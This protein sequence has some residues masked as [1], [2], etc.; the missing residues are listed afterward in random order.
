[1]TL[2]MNRHVSLPNSLA[3][4]FKYFLERHVLSISLQEHE[5]CLYSQ[6]TL[7]T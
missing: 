3:K 4:R 2:F 7:H 1:M 5:T 6:N